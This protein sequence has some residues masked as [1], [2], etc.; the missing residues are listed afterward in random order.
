MVRGSY[1][2]FGTDKIKKEV[3]FSNELPSSGRAVFF[4][5]LKKGEVI[6]I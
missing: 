5:K 1:V 2:L 6:D 3:K 4:G